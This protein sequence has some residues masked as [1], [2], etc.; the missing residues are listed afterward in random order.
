MIKVF[1]FS[2]DELSN[3]RSE[4][5]LMG[6]KIM[7]ESNRTAEKTGF[8]E[9]AAYNPAIDLRTDFVMVY[10]IDETTTERIKVWKD[11]GY[12]VHLMTGVAWG[13]YQ[14]YLY[15][16]FDDRNH[17]DEAQRDRHDEVIGHGVD[18]PYMV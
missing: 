9:A 14:D 17:W 13:E 12:V 8:Q 15:G 6:G 18:V 16:K 10:G 1:C 4:D 5:L 7:F 2:G 11:R 3:D